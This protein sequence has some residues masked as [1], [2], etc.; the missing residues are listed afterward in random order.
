VQGP[1][2]AGFSVRPGY[3]PSRPLHSPAGGYVVRDDTPNTYRDP[4]RD[5][6]LVQKA[7]F[8][9]TYELIP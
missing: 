2:L 1:G 9:S 4:P 8:E 3:D 7:L 5:V 6:W